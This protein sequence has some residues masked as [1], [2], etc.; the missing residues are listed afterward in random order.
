MHTCR[1]PDA[2][3]FITETDEIGHGRPQN[4]VSSIS[5]S[6]LGRAW[7]CLPG[8]PGDKWSIAGAAESGAVVGLRG[9]RPGAASAPRAPLR[10]WEV[11]DCGRTW[12]LCTGERVCGRAGRA[13]GRAAALADLVPGPPGVLW[14]FRGPVLEEALLFGPWG[15]L[16]TLAA[17]LGGQCLA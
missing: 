17:C 14:G 5:A 6:R 8:G 7:R 2:G 9:A 15:S 3:S 4:V 16:A 13:A 1:H 11:R 12:Q 10:Q